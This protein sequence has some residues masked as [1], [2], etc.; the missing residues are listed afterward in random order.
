MILDFYDVGVLCD[1]KSQ[2]ISDIRGL[3]LDIDMPNVPERGAY[4]RRHLC[5]NNFSG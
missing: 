3:N 4:C 2:L 5:T 1:A